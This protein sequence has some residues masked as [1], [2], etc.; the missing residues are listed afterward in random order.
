[1]KKHRIAAVV[2]GLIFLG[3]GQWMIWQPHRL[4]GYVPS[5]RNYL[6]K[7][8]LVK[9]WGIPAGVVM[10]LLGANTLYYFFMRRDRKAAQK[11]KSKYPK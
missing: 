8:L 11:P 9:I 7:S 3:L 4:D 1:M 2:W 6:A 10:S 5:G